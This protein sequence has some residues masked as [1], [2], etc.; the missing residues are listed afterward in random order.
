ML[1]AQ[2][3]TATISFA[4]CQVDIFLPC[5]KRIS[6]KKCFYEIKDLIWS[7]WSKSVTTRPTES[8]ILHNY[9]T[10]SILKSTAK[11]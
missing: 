9:S 10:I 7:I 11:L 6:G 2:A 3:Y 1:Q 5:L 4:V 8:N